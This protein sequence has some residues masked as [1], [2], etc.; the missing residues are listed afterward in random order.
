MRRKPNSFMKKLSLLLGITSEMTAQERL[1]QFMRDQQHINLLE[2]IK[3]IRTDSYFIP[4]YN[5]PKVFTDVKITVCG[6]PIN[7]NT[8]TTC[9]RPIDF[10]NDIKAWKKFVSLDHKKEIKQKKQLEEDKQKWALAIHHNYAPHL[11]KSMMR[12]D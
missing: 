6:T 9:E 5:K 2:R 8:I 12:L 7:S 1:A 10:G 4:D 3:A 11:M